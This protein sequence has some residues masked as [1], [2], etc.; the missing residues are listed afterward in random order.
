MNENRGGRSVGPWN[1]FL[2]WRTSGNGPERLKETREVDEENGLPVGLYV[3]PEGSEEAER[4]GP[5]N[6]LPVAVLSPVSVVAAAVKRYQVTPMIATGAYTAADQV[7]ALQLLPISGS[8]GSKLLTVT[9]LDRAQQRSALDLFFFDRTVTLAADDAAFTVTDAD[10]AFCIGVVSVL[11]ADYDDVAAVSSIATV[12]LNPCL[13]IPGSL[14][15]NVYL[16]IVA[17]GA[18]TYGA[19]NGLVLSFSYEQAVS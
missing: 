9:V 15:E 14:D 5:G 16:A 18:P 12:A 13:A 19:V 8:Y 4:V 6:P 17:R 7:G 1:P 2:I 11:T 3:V 10:M